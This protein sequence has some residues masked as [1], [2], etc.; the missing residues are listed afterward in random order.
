V[1]L[2]SP[3]FFTNRSTL[4]TPELGEAS[5]ACA[6]TA[7]VPV[8][9]SWALVAPELGATV[10]SSVVLSALPFAASSLP[11]VSWAIV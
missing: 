9:S 8:L 6:S 2:L 4:E 3:G 1:K 10:S 5:V 7:I 11:A